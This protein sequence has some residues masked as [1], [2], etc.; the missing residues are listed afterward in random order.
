MF[1]IMEAVEPEAQVYKDCPHAHKKHYRFGFIILHNLR[2][3]MA[4]CY[5]RKQNK[6]IYKVN[7]FFVIPALFLTH[8][9]VVF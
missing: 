7:V 4:V 9:A 2:I 5:S 3:S 1:L 6:K 8:S